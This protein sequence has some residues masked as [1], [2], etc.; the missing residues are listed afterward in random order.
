MPG[1]RSPRRLRGWR[2]DM[3]K[4]SARTGK[5]MCV[6]FCLLGTC[7]ITW[8]AEIDVRPNHLVS[9]PAPKLQR[10]EVWVAASRENPND[11]VAVFHAGAKLDAPTEGWDGCE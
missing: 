6:I 11:S 10:N 9:L 4:G 1:A 5:I 8:A 3:T 2:V 7:Q